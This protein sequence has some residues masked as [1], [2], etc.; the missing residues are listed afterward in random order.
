[1][2]FIAGSSFSHGDQAVQWWKSS[3]KA[4][5][6]SGG[7][8]MSTSRCTRKLSG[9]VAANPSTATM[10]TT[11]TIAMIFSMKRV[12]KNWGRQVKDLS[13]GSGE[14]SR[15]ERPVTQGWFR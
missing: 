11:M 1:M 13:R 9:R 3:I 2:R 14:R 4:N 7:A 8:L 6:F 5:T 12:S 10:A 15:P